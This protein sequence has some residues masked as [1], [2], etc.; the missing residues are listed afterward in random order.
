MRIQWLASLCAILSAGSAEPAKTVAWSEIQRAIAETI[1]FPVVDG[2]T[3]EQPM[4]GDRAACG[5]KAP[6]NS[7]ASLVD[8]AMTD[9]SPFLAP[10]IGYERERDE[11]L[12]TIPA[13][14]VEARAA[15]AR[16]ILLNDPSFTDPVLSRVVDALAARGEICPDCPPRAKASPRSVSSKDVTP[17]VLAFILVDPVRTVDS[18][19]R[20]LGQPRFSFHICTG[21]NAV[22]TLPHD[23]RLARAGYVAAARAMSRKAVGD[24]FGSVLG[25]DAF[26]A[27][28]DD[29]ARTAY[30]RKRLAEQLR[31]GPDVKAAICAVSSDL[32]RDAA[33]V[34][35][36]CPVK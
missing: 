18:D 13:G 31:A 22:R 23:E 2:S 11:R 19:G 26:G 35:T 10:I 34:V 16:T 28:A 1:C 14:S 5:A 21:L 7:V 25:E 24:A 4:F 20:P 8:A 30:L 9:A 15:A 17:Y 33:L 3:L 32:R 6:P 12:R 36:D 29:A 27:L